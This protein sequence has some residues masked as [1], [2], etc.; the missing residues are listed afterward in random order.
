[1]RSKSPL[2]NWLKVLRSCFSG[3]AFLIGMVLLETLAHEDNINT[4]NT[5]IA[6]LKKAG[7]YWEAASGFCT[8]RILGKISLNVLPIPS[9]LVTSS[10]A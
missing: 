5:L 7:I 4:S 3:T 1:M 10:L 6:M 9:S 8:I 2:P